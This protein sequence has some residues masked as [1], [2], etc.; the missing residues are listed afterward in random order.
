MGVLKNINLLN[1]LNA[2]LPAFSLLELGLVLIIIGVLVGAVFKGDELLQSARLN[3][4]LDDVRRLRNAVVMYQQNY[5]N[6]PGDDAAASLHFKIAQD[7]NG[8]GLVAGRDESLV[9]QHLAAAGTLAHAGVPTAKI[10][11]TYRITS[12]INEQF[13]GIFLLLGQGK[14]SRDGVMTPKQAQALKNKADD[15]KPDEGLIQ[16]IDGVGSA[17]SCVHNNAFNLSNDKPSCVM[18]VKLS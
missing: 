15:G 1:K 10:G 9:W 16:F 3:S 7:G 5:G 12:N 4:V 18:V 8:D 6:L 2:R 17:G 14:D 13:H 11:G